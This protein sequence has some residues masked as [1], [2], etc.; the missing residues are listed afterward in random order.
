MAD[1]YYSKSRFYDIDS[2]IFFEATLDEFR[3]FIV[4][5][6]E[7]LFRLGISSIFEI[8][9]DFNY[10]EGFKNYLLNLRTNWISEDHYICTDGL[11]IDFEMF[12]DM[13]AKYKPL[14][15]FRWILKSYV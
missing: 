4:N 12:P 6:N 2:G 10:S 3:R 9:Q 1:F 7:S 8:L 15:Q 13:S 11:Y 5:V 14:Y